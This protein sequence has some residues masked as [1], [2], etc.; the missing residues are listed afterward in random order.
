MAS[1]HGKT[2]RSGIHS[3][4]RYKGL[5]RARQL[6]QEHGFRLCPD[7]DDTLTDLRCAMRLFKPLPACAVPHFSENRR[8]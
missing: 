1:L 5:V 6:E 8:S 2:A 7:D 4:R 3:S